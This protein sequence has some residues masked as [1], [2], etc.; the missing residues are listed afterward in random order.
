MGNQ[1]AKKKDQK[2]KIGSK[3]DSK[4]SSKVGSKDVS[5]MQTIQTHY[6]AVS[7]SPSERVKSQFTS[8]NQPKSVKSLFVS[9]KSSSPSTYHCPSSS[10]RIRRGPDENPFFQVSSPSILEPNDMTEIYNLPEGNLQTREDVLAQRNYKLEKQI[11]KGAYSVVYKGKNQSTG[12]DI[13]CKIITFVNDKNID[14]R[15]A[16]M[17][18]ELFVLERNHH[19]YIMTLYE[20]FIIDNQLYIIMK[21]A[22]NGSLTKVLKFKGPMS[23]KDCKKPFAQIVCGLQHMHNKGICHRDLKC[24][25]ILFDSKINAIITDFG[26]SRIG[27]R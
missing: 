22:Y 20:H 12:K 21:Y 25:N 15:I 4:I 18:N 5:S 11:G 19:P 27:Y 10:M 13:A 1:L 2:Y 23:E 3:I 8:T 9:S 14:H 17:K 7:Q 26:L 24:D 16:D 6:E